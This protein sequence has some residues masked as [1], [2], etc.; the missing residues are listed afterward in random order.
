MR[1]RPK[2]TPRVYRLRSFSRSGLLALVV[3][4]SLFKFG[5][6]ISPTPY[7]AYN[8]LLPARYK[9]DAVVNLFQSR[10]GPYPSAFGPSA[11]DAV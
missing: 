1:I 9:P 3:W 6:G 8:P 5:L 2:L 10:A 4:T 7:S 11:Q